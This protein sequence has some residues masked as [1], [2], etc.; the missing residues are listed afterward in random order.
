MPG[1]FSR[2]SMM[3]LDGGHDDRPDD[4]LSPVCTTV[5]PIES[6]RIMIM[7]M[8]LDDLDAVLAIANDLQL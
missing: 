6:L 8:D 7:I 2:S 1:E 3:V 4:H 5:Q